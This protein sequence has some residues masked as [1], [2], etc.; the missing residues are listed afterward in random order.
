M[1]LTVH[2]PDCGAEL[3]VAPV[4][5]RVERIM[6]SKSDRGWRAIIEAPAI[7]HNC[8]TAGP[9]DA[10]TDPAW[11]SSNEPMLACGCGPDRAGARHLEGCGVGDGN[12]SPAWRTCCHTYEGTEHL[13]DC[14]RWRPPE[15]VG[16]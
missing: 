5:T 1:T 14:E 12:V 2:C 4:V 16:P 8:D 6:R 11:L 9:Q 13:V 3:R 7:R 15:Q 10:A